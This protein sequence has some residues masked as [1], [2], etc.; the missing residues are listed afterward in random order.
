MKKFLYIIIT[1][2]MTISLTLF[3]ISYKIKNICVDTISDSMIKKEISDKVL[4]YIYELIPTMSIDDMSKIDNNIQESDA[5][6]D[7]AYKFYD[8][9]IDSIK[10]NTSVKTPDIKNDVKKLIDD[11]MNII[12]NYNIKIDSEM[13]EKIIDN[14]D[15]TSLYE[16]D[17]NN[18]KNSLTDEQLSAVKIYITISSSTFS[19]V[20]IIISLISIG[21]I[22]FISKSK[23]DWMKYSQLSLIISGS[24]L[25][26]ILG[27]LVNEV[28]PSVTNKLLGRTATINIQSIINV[29][30]IYLV[31]GI[32]L[33]IIYN[34]TY[35][36]KKANN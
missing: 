36:K 24:L 2:I 22:A 10:N 30:Y 27:L 3:G 4:D 25:S 16:N 8:S 1:L 11:N 29:G 20:T 23:Y 26:F 33:I 28:S 35:N 21:L 18:I 34:I 6:K 9:L 32:I 7:I 13:E 17:A 5:T 12:N 19:I 14:I 31:L 15:I